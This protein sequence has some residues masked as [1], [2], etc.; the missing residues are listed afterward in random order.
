MIKLFL[1]YR[2]YT[3]TSDSVIG[4]F[5]VETHAR[6]F[7]KECEHLNKFAG[8]RVEET[9]L[10]TYGMCEETRRELIQSVNPIV[11]KESAN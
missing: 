3:G 6:Q 5:L 1:V 2:K 8:I 10:S 4:A 11:R 7:A 9:C